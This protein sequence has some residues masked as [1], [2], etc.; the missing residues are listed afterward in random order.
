MPGSLTY[1]A[2]Q[3]LGRTASVVGLA[4]CL[5]A[6]GAWG[7]APP[8]RSGAQPAETTTEPTPALTPPP[9][10]L[11][12]P[13]S[14]YPLELLG[15]LGPATQ[16]GPVTLTPSLSIVEEYNDNIF[17][18]NQ[19]R[20]WDFI[21]TL[22]PAVTL[23]VN[24]PSYQ[25]NAGFSFSAAIYAKE[26]DLTR[27][28]DSMNF[29][30]GGAYRVSPAL[31]LNVSESF[32]LSNY[33]SLTSA[34][35]AS[36]TQGSFST[37]RERSWNN[38]FSPGMSWQM[39]PVNSLNLVV[40]Y[41]ALRF[42]GN[43]VGIDSDTYQLQS[44][45][46]HTFTPRFSGNVGYGF[47]YLDDRAADNSINHTPTVGF[48][49]RL[50]PTL[51]G[52]VTGGATISQIGGDA[53]VTPTGSVSLAQ[54][55]QFGSASVTYSR[56]VAVAGGFGGTSDTQTASGIFTVTTLLR[57]LI[58]AFSPTYSTAES[59]NSQSSNRSQSSNQVDVQSFTLA[60]DAAYQINRY[61]SVFAGY[62]FLHQRTGSASSSQFDADQNRVRVGVQFGYPFTF[63]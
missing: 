26:T 4:V 21:T 53:F 32:V 35:S 27:A 46:V 9:P 23:A 10:V 63:N 7:Q 47:T 60:L 6:S 29:I 43:G 28:L 38:T 61:T 58:V 40:S 24:Q 44:T 45:F 34:T 33:T 19:N 20:V 8:S 39:S 13:L 15:L 25:L 54:V 57:G 11:L 42:E 55:W 49:Y 14:A 18:D 36:S 1:N 48:S 17:L 37:G 16:R 51:T 30:A 3:M 22:S 31:T 5:M 41:S 52:A 50:T 12:R 59:V 2:S 56:Y 62:T